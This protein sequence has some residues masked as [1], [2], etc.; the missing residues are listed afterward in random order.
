MALAWGCQRANY[1]AHEMLSK[2][3]PGILESAANGLGF[4]RLGGGFLLEKFITVALALVFGGF[5]A[6]LG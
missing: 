2:H 1:G 3:F 4:C 5:F 6:E